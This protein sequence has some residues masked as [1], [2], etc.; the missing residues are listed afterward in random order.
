LLLDQT[1]LPNLR[2]CNAWIL[3]GLTSMCIPPRVYVCVL[4]FCG[5]FLL[6]CTQLAIKALADEEHNS[7]DGLGS[8]ASW[9]DNARICDAVAALYTD[10]PQMHLVRDVFH[11]FHRQ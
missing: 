1:A 11:C 7:A 8:S 4:K 6:P 5:K 9:S 2:C 3:L 10:W